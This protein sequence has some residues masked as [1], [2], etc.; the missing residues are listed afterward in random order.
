METE[1]ILAPFP[2]LFGSFAF[3]LGAC[4]GSFLNVVI[5]RLPRGE[6]LGGRSHCSCG[7]MI[8]WHDNIPI[9][10]WVILRG[11]ARCCGSPFSIR[12]PLVELLVGLLFLGVWLQYPPVAAGIFAVFVS[13]MV[14]AAVV[15][16]DTM[17]I[18]DSTSIGGFILGV[19][20]SFA[21]P[22]LH[23][24]SGDLY[25]FDAFQSGLSAVINGFVA[26]ALILWIGILS[27]ALLKKETM[28]FGDVKLMA[29]IGAFCGW[30]GGLF[31]LFGGA[32]IGTVCLA[33]WYGLKAVWPRK[34][35]EIVPESQPVSAEQG[36]R[37]AFELAAK[38]PDEWEIENTGPIPFGPM[39]V[40]GALVYLI[41]LREPVDAFFFELQA[42]IFGG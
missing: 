17:E 18:P 39:L 4:I 6:T 5:L 40:A 25:L 3:V 11:R 9:L 19:L 24:V 32:T 42:L 14:V 16:L 7:Q 2:W 38:H 37:E 30:Q 22:Q 10:G 13:L 20:A 26:S 21:W 1:A 28:G 36:Y 34:A 33:L 23:G 35:G 29:A 15:D 12:Y 31:A 8:R 27:S 41:L